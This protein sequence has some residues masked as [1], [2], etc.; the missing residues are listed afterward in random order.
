MTP[1]M[2]LKVITHI[3]SSSLILKSNKIKIYFMIS[4]SFCERNRSAYFFVHQVQRNKIPSTRGEDLVYLHNSNS[5]LG[6]MII[7]HYLWQD[8][9]NCGM[10]EA[11]TLVYLMVLKSLS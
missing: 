8:S 11:N 5:F 10:L 6:R 1:R 3:S 9:Q 2:A 4:S 7:D